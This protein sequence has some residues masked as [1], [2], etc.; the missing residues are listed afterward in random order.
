M[1]LA[2]TPQ[3]ARQMVVHKKVRINGSVVNIP[4]YLVS[5][6]EESKI[7]VQHPKYKPKPV[8]KEEAKEA[9]E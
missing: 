4:S 9:T 7:T 2:R 3:Q 8:E 1:N 6:D 5:V